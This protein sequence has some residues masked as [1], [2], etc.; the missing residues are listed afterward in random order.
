MQR[1]LKL[2]FFALISSVFFVKVSGAD[3]VSIRGGKPLVQEGIIEKIK[4]NGEV[5]TIKNGQVEI[6]KRGEVSKATLIK[7]YGLQSVEGGQTEDTKVYGGEQIILGEGSYAYN[8]EIY[9]EGET[10]GQQN[11]Y[12]GGAAFFTDVMSGGEQNIDRWF[13]DGEG[14]LAVDTKVFSGGVQNVL[15]GGK[16]SSITLEEGALQRVYSGGYVEDL[17]IKS[18]AIS[19]VYG[20]A[21][22]AGEV[23]VSDSGKFYLYAG[24]GQ[25]Q[26]KVENILLNGK[27]SQLY[28]VA[29]EGDGSSTLIQKLRG[30][31][32]VIFTASS[33]A[34]TSTMRNP[35]YSL[36]SVQNLSGNID[37]NFRINTAERY[38]DYLIVE[39]GAGNH[40]VSI[41]DSGSEITNSSFHSV[42]LITDKSGEANFSLKNHSVDGGAYMYDLKQKSEK[43][44]KIWYLAATKKVSTSSATAPNA[45]TSIAGSLGKEENITDLQ[46]PIISSYESDLDFY[47]DNYRVGENQLVLQNSTISDGNMVISDDNS[48]VYFFDDS[49]ADNPKLS[50]NN[51]IE[52]SGILYV[53]DGGFSKNTTVMEGGSEVIGEQGISEFTIVYEGGRQSVEGG[54]SALKTEIYGGDQLIFGDGYVNGGIV[55]SSAYNTKIYGQGGKPGQQS[56]YDGGMAMGTQIMHGGMQN[57]AKW[58]ADDEDFAEKTGGLAVNTEVFAGG[59]QRILAGGNADIVT[60]YKGAF[61][62]VHAGGSVKNLTIEGGASSWASAGAILGGEVNISDSGKLYIYAGDDSQ[63]T[64]VENIN[65]IG[66]ESQLYALASHFDDKSTYIQSLS[67]VGRVTFTSPMNRLYY[68]QLYID[69]LSGS[70]HF[71]LNVSLAEGKGD[72][73]FIENGSGYHTISV[74]D[75]GIQIIDHSSTKL[76]L[77]FDQSGGADFTL[78][79]FSGAKVEFVDGGTYTYGLKWENSEDGRAKIWYLTAVYM[80]SS[81]GRRRTLRHL[82]QNQ[83]VSVF[84]TI[85]TSEEHTV[86]LSRSRGNRRKLSEESLASFHSAA[87]SGEEYIVGERDGNDIHS[88]SCPKLSRPLHVATLSREKKVLKPSYQDN[89]SQDLKQRERIPDFLTTPSTD[90]V[91]SLSVSPGFIFHNE[92]QAVRA[93]RGVLDRDKKDAALWIYTIKSKEAISADHLDFKLEQTGIVLGL[94]GLSEWENGEFY[95]GGFGSY[96]Q[97]RVAHA[98]GGVSSINAYSV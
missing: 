98:R 94:S 33:T 31:G 20:G 74:I 39:K 21:E 67:G 66:E 13:R 59:L 84:S 73:L 56:V 70:M 16:A 40:M 62:E 22:L 76:D 69:D 61:Q 46:D 68:S 29:T 3:G 77:I 95:I 50:M 52:G 97:A 75:S 25:H 8:S 41:V 9:G 64:T 51:T 4:E 36:L 18:G 82:N 28:S 65:L 23:K 60:L 26:T 24:S 6:V 85:T 48:T 11:V 32:R 96:D 88:S 14:G 42:D 15:A 12:D 89:F 55:G 86:A 10:L 17:T 49:M 19:L 80:D 58:F 54:G 44:E 90:A 37:F 63:R 71:N 1:K 5:F 78:K 38:G 72:Y 81:L 53:E 43:G 47:A 30:K 34:A 35:Y 83:P 91:L 45:Q 27:E 79:S 57:L 93:G 7:K 2:S 92:L 87:S